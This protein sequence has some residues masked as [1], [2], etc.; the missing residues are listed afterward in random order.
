MNLSHS[1]KEL[2]KAKDSLEKMKEI[3]LKDDKNLLTEFESNW[4]DFLINLEKIWKKSELECQ[5]IPQFQPWQ[6]KYKR[7]RK[8]DPLLRYLKNARDADQHSIQPITEEK[9][10]E[11]KIISPLEGAIYTEGDIIEIKAEFKEPRI[12]T[13]KFNNRGVVYQPPEKHLDHY[14]TN[15]KDPIELAELGIKYY[16]EYLSQIREKFN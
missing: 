2:K 11:A 15:P 14:L 16:E 8:K 13:N 4:V 12:E 1:E 7:E 9:G 3:K 5:E 6:G 10:Y